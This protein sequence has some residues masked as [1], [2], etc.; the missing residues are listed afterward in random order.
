MSGEGGGGGVFGLVA[1][2]GAPTLSYA[3]PTGGMSSAA[4]SYFTL[5]RQSSDRPKASSGSSRSVTAT[6]NGAAAGPASMDMPIGMRSMPVGGSNA[7]HRA[8]SSN[9]R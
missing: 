6:F 5:S 2:G 8:A 9:S 7:F 3:V 4:A 1:A